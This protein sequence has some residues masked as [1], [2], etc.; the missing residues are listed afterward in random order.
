MTILITFVIIIIILLLVL[1]IVLEMN[2]DHEL[3]KYF[4]LIFGVIITIIGALEFPKNKQFKKRRKLKIFFLGLSLFL[5][6]GCAI[7][8]EHLVSIEHKIETSRSDSLSRE[9][10][11]ELKK[12][13]QIQNT[14]QQERRENHKNDSI[15]YSNQTNRTQDSVRLLRNIVNDNQK[16]ERNANI[17]ELLLTATDLSYEYG[18]FMTS[19]PS[20]YDTSDVAEIKKIDYFSKM[21]IILDRALK[22]SFLSA[23]PKL[24]SEWDGIELGV[25]IYVNWKQE[26]VMPSYVLQQNFIQLNEEIPNFIHL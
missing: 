11:N 19:R 20:Q 25:N 9:V 23:N 17:N 4:E 15:N 14:D 6:C 8:S 2:S 26:K 13:I 24:Q 1:Y 22:N 21:K 7:Y 18:K 16:T 3:Y 10:N 12:Q 5:G